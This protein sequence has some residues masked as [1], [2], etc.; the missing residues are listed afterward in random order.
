MEWSTDRKAASA[1]WQSTFCARGAAALRGCQWATP[2]ELVTSVSQ[3]LT[4]WPGDMEE[5]DVV[6]QRSAGAPRREPYDLTVD[7]PT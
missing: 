7:R 3:P 2:L 5:R 6:A 4:F 1:P